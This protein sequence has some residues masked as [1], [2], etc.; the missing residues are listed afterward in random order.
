MALLL[1]SSCGAEVVA[2]GA[3]GSGGAGGSRWGCT[4]SAQGCDCAAP[5][6]AAAASCAMT[7]TCCVAYDLPSGATTT[8]SCHCGNLEATP[9]AALFGRYPNRKQVATCPPR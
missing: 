5:G 4:E 7:W 6:M 3:G 2:P 1:L 8:P 9:C